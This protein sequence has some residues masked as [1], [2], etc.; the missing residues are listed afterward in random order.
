MSGA[1]MCRVLG[2]VLMG[3]E[4]AE[5]ASFFSVFFVFFL[6]LFVNVVAFFKR[7]VLYPANRMTA[8]ANLYSAIF[9]CC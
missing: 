3:A 2:R 8:T 9:A 5:W 1:Q 7:F 6:S 4:C